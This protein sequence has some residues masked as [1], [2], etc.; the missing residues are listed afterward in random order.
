MNLQK[1]HYINLHQDI[2]KTPQHQ[3]SIDLTGPYNTTSQGSSYTLTA[4]C[5]LTG[6]LMMT[7]IPD[8]RPMTVAIHMFSDIML[9]FS[10]PRILHSDNRIEFKTKLIEDLSQ[11]LGI[12][13]TY[14]SPLPPPG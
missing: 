1:L 13:K 6:Y 9:K 8:K 5:S 4:V 14:I 10:F 11:Q 12:M 2:A 3:I 7:S